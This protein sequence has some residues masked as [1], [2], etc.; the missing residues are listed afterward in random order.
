MCGAAAP[1]SFFILLMLTLFLFFPPGMVLSS[2][3]GGGGVGASTGLTSTRPIALAELSQYSLEL[4]FDCCSL[5]GLRL[6]I[7]SLLSWG[8]KGQRQK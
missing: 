4:R 3:V 7:I 5:L 6:F 2:S 8:I 1:R